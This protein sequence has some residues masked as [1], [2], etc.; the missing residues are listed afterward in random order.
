MIRPAR[1]AAATLGGI[2][3]FLASFVLFNVVF[4]LYV[5]NRYPHPGSTAGA[6]AFYY[7]LPVGATAA[8]FVF[9]MILIKTRAW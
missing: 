5:E 1:L 4:L 6:A 7:G 3:A 8:A 9:L 2:V